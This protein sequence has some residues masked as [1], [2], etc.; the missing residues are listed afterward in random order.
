MSEPAGENIPN[1]DRD[2]AV[3]LFERAA[4]KVRSFP[5]RPGVYLMKD[6]EG[7]VIYVGKATNLRARVRSY[8]STDTRRKTG[9]LILASLLAG[10]HCA[11]GDD[12]QLEALSRC[13]TALGLAFQIVDDILDVTGVAGDL[14]K[15]AG[16]DE[17]AG[18]STFPALMGLQASRTR[19]TEL[20]A[21]ARAALVSLGAAADPLRDLVSL[22]TERIS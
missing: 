8:F 17:R 5:A 12:S 3:R 7:R 15:S 21:E 11:G 18:K 1:D 22:A 4:E 14:G 13:G 10:G 9:A 2:R 19:A 20:A 16:K 6:A